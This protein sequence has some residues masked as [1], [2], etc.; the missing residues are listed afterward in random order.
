MKQIVLIVNL[1]ISIQL[2][3]QVSNLRC[4]E[5][6]SFYHLL[7]VV[8]NSKF[9][10]HIRVSLT[11]QTIDLYSNDKISFQG[12]LT[13][14]ITE[15][16]SVKTKGGERSES[17]QVVYQTFQLDSTLSSEVATKILQSGQ[18]NIPTDSLVKNWKKWY[19]HCGSI[20]FQFK[21]NN[22]YIEQS[23]H[24]PWSQPDSVEFKKTIISNYKFLEDKLQLET[25][26]GT[27]ESLLPK[28]KT[29]SKD[30]YGIM[31]IMTNEQSKAWEKDRP[32]RD[33]L[34]SIKDTIND[35][36]NNRL[37]E[38]RVDYGSKESPCFSATLKFNRKGKLKSV[39]T[40]KSD[41]PKIF[42]GLSSYFEEMIEETKCKKS[43]KRIF[44]NINLASFNTK[45]DI[46]R[47]FYDFSDGGWTI[48][49]DTMY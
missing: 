46:Y 10:I 34:K 20:F 44:E 15:Y 11:G 40:N 16:K 12:T 2:H 47:T 28:G 36:L 26:F 1:I 48:V 6:D 41:R 17:S 37:K 42:D 13:N 7:P 27:F 32:K 31:Y 21:E 14:N 4:S 43:I 39:K 8:K 9:K 45:Y 29:Y 25:R 38:V 19:L 5:I 49:D 33:Y 18:D 23:F 24:C 22:N 3:G 30:G 35:F